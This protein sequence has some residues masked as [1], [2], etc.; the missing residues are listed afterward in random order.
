MKEVAAEETELEVKHLSLACYKVD[1]YHLVPRF[2]VTTEDE[3]Y[4]LPYIHVHEIETIR[5]LRDIL[6][7]CGKQGVEVESDKENHVHRINQLRLTW[8]KAPIIKTYPLR[9]VSLSKGLLVTSFIES[10]GFDRVQQFFKQHDVLHCFH[11]SESEVVVVLIDDLLDF[12][13]PSVLT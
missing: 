13:V 3:T 5:E 7:N 6:D 1:R 4:N 2:L 8:L 11:D 12:N 9:I 10:T